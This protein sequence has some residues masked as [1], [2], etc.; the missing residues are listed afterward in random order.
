MIKQYLLSGIIVGATSFICYLLARDIGYIVVSLILLF[1]VSILA[2]FM[3]VGPIILASAL[4]AIVWNFFFIPPR[5]TFHIEKGEDVL[6]FA[7]FFTIALVNGILTTRVRR[8]QR[9]THDREKKTNSLFQLTRELSTASGM[10]NIVSVAAENIKKYFSLNAFFFLQ[11][12]TDVLQEQ[13]ENSPGEKLSPEE[14]SIA[15]LAFNQAKKAGKYTD[16]ETSGCY[17]YYP[18]SATRIKLGVLAIRQSG[19]FLRDTNDYWETFLT[20][21]SNAVEREFLDELAR[22]ARFLDE[23]ERLYKTLFNSISHELRIPVATIIGA[24]DS[25]L[26]TEHN[27]ETSDDLTHE[28]VKASVRLNR[29]IE[30][31]LNMSRIESGHIS[32]HLDWC[33]VRDLINKVIETLR[34]EL[35]PF[36]LLVEIPDDMPL[37]K[38]DFGLIEQ[39]LY[40]LVYNASLYAPPSSEM[41]VETFYESENFYLILQDRGPGL[42]DQ[43]LSKIFEKFYKGRVTK[44][45]GIGLGLSI[46]KGFVE[47]HKGQIIAENRQNG[48]ARF[49][50][51][52][53]SEIPDLRIAYNGEDKA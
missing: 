10:K 49:T 8:Q 18:L 38:L 14:Y 43:N 20:Q 3:E 22:K 19:P 31:L 42:P 29:L 39:V 2:T 44:A 7:M 4:S 50:I 48:G 1:I 37:V 34:D 15:T 9:I 12:G 25:L 51:K 41:K 35:R 28:I 53:P 11:N 17:T 27:K 40:N 6:M 36:N 45:G 21:I 30:N 13:S 26:M 47:A 5:Y 16:I 52:I 46:V 32:P 33:D 23:S 24:S